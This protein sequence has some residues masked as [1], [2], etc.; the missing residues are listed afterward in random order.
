MEEGVDGIDGY[1]VVSG[2]E[3]L[4]QISR[5]GIPVMRKRRSYLPVLWSRLSRS[6]AASFRETTLWPAS[7]KKKRIFRMSERSSEERR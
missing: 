3:K 5:W 7:R 4:L 1:I 2:N 6:I